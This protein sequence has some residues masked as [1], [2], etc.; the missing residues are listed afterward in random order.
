MQLQAALPANFS[1]SIWGIVPGVTFPYFGQTQ[2]VIWGTVYMSY[3]GVDAGSGIT[4][5]D[6]VNGT[7]AYPSVVTN[8]NG[9]YAF[10]LNSILASGS[11]VLVYTTSGIAFQESASGSVAALN[12]YGTY[13]SENTA[14]ASANLSTVTS[15]LA[16]AIGSDAGLL[17]TTANL[18]IN[19][20]ASSFTID[21]MISTGT[22]VLSGTGT[23]AQSKPI[24][25]TDLDLLGSGATYN[26][27]NTSDS[28]GTLAANIGSGGTVNLYDGIDLIIGAVDGIN[29]VTAGTFNLAFANGDGVTQ[30]QPVSVTDLSLSGNGGTDTLT[31]TANSIGTLAADA[32][33]IDVYDKTALTIGTVN[34]TA[35]VT[36]TATTGLPVEL[37]SL[38]AMTI[39][40]GAPVT[41]GGAILLAADGIFTNNDGASGVSAGTGAYY[42]IYSQDS[43]NPTTVLPADTFGG[44]TATDYYNDAFNFTTETFATAPP[45]SGQNLF[46]YGYA[47]SLT[48]TLSGSAVMTYDDTTMAPTTNLSVGASLLNASDDATF[49]FTSAAYATANAGTNINVTAS[50]ISLVSNPNN[51]TLGSTTA[52]APVGTIKAESITITAVTNTKTYDSTTSAAALPMLS[53]GTLY[54]VD[55]ATLS[56][57]Y[58][59]ANAG[60]NLTLTPSVSFNPAGNAAGANNYAI[61]YVNNTTGVISPATLTYVAD[62]ATANVGS[63]FPLFTGTVTGLV[64]RDTLASATTGTLLWSTPATPTSAPGSYPIDGSG[65]TAN[66]GNYTFVQAAGNA[67]ALTL[68]PTLPPPYTP[69]NPSNNPPNNPT[70]ITFQNSNFLFHVSFTPNGLANNGNNVN[71][72]SLSPGDQF[73]HN[74]GFNFAPISQYDDNQYSDFKLPP[75]DNDDSESAILTILARGASPGHGQD[76]MVDNFWNGTDATWPGPGH[77]GL[78][79]KLTFSDGAG[80]DVTPTNDDGFPIVAGKT[81]FAQLLKNGP[82]M[83]DGPP[84]QTP[85]QWLL[86]TGMT[87]DGKDIICDDPATGGLVELA[88]DPTTETI[89]G[90]TGVFNPKTNGFVALADAGGD[91]PANDASGL[92]GLQSF[93]PSTYY[94]VTVH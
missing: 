17:P 22:L 14:A 52:T 12:I 18:A 44:L 19:I 9:E 35:G 79:G 76:Y 82:V 90:I 47:A 61:I 93:V 88:Y 84:G 41:S 91:I 7:A 37:V 80:H 27:T 63:P 54:S 64:G 62:P 16:T 50:G 26:L 13:L 78:S 36:A 57:S 86:A 71:P 65:L 51:Y 39:A 5:S 60:T 3:G 43:T 70:N 66:F 31:N 10:V 49:A 40:N 53:N 29:G 38:G 85:A 46:V 69:P 56:E 24:T 1:S 77:I 23:V 81:D 83:I 15:D 48:P 20:G 68:G 94:A 6:L 59:T 58:T 33:S 87:P 42:S 73:T 28:I 74:N 89:G 4:V 21:K 55:G 92:A 25:A 34:G 32:G 30:T 8:G 75:Y 11:Q 67:T 72:A 45:S 2:S